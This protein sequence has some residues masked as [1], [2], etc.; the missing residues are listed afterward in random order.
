[1]RINRAYEVL[2]DEDLRKHYDEYGEDDGKAGQNQQYQSWQ[3]YRDN[4]GLEYF[5]FQFVFLVL[6]YFGTTYI[7]VDFYNLFS[8]WRSSFIKL[9]LKYVF[10][11]FILV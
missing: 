1:M 2:K 3:F 10:L 5:Y 8:K 11:V 7:F 9:K 4:F 6:R